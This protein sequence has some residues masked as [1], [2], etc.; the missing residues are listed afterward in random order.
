ML[1]GRFLE[2]G[3]RLFLS[4]HNLLV[5]SCFLILLS[6]LSFVILVIL[7][8]HIPGCKALRNLVFCRTFRVVCEHIVFLF[9]SF[10]LS[11][12]VGASASR[13]KHSGPCFLSLVVWFN[14]WHSPIFGRRR[15]NCPITHRDIL[16]FGRRYSGPYLLVNILSTVLYFLGHCE[17]KP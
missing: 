11:P 12:F 10:S 8:C 14:L 3:K 9:F 4:C 16:S 15:L 1:R 5:F 7:A 17:L 2:P 6:H 13:L